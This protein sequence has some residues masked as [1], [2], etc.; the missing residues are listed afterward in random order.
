MSYAV[1]MSSHLGLSFIDEEN[2]STISLN[3]INGR[4]L[5]M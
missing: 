2:K 1:T 4:N 5:N 3:V